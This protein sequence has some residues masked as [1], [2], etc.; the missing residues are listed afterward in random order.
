MTRGRAHAVGQELPD[1]A[2]ERRR[3]GLAH[4]TERRAKVRDRVVI[5]ICP[6]EYLAVGFLHA[7]KFL[8]LDYRIYGRIHQAQAWPLAKA[9]CLL[10][11]YTAN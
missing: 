3:G 5:E 9:K 1:E 7:T 4:Y 6:E 8:R 11:S 10:V 2:L